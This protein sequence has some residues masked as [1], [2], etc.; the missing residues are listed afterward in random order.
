MIFLLHQ[1]K[2]SFM[3][4][5]IIVAGIILVTNILY[6]QQVQPIFTNNPFPKTITVSG[7][8]EME[9]IPDEICVNIELKEYQKRGESKKDIETIKSE[10]LQSCKTAGIPDSSIS[11]ASYN[12]FNTYYWFRKKKKDPNLNSGISYQVKFKNSD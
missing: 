4:K 6:G 11:I 12:G 3:K 2:K 8:A 5:L 10:F 9:I 1:T 7:S